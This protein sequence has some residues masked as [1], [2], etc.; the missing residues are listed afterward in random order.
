MITDSASSAANIAGRSN[1]PWIADHTA[2]AAPAA[3]TATIYARAARGRAAKFMALRSYPPRAVMMSADDSRHGCG[4]HR[5]RRDRRA[6]RPRVGTR[7]PEREQGRHR[8]RTALRRRRLVALRRDQ[9]AARRARRSPAD[10]RRGAAHRQPRAPDAG[11]ESRRGARAARGAPAACGQ[12][13]EEA[14][15]DQTRRRRARTASRV[16]EAARRREIVAA[17]AA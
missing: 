4:G 6:L 14:P 2:R 1:A 3:R 7:R 12:A 16:E 13:A 9:A 5:R 11:A 8:G 10:E 15:S 17:T